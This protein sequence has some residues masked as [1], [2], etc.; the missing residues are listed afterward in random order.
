MLTRF[1]KQYRKTV[2]ATFKI[3]GMYFIR[4]YGMSFSSIKIL[5]YIFQ[6]FRP[7]LQY[8][9]LATSLLWKFSRR[10]GNSTVKRCDYLRYCKFYTHT[11]YWEI[12]FFPA[13]LIC[14]CSDPRKRITRV[15]SFSFLTE[16]IAFFTIR[17]GGISY[18][19]ILDKVCAWKK[20]QNSIR[21]SVLTTLGWFPVYKDY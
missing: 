4:N 20:T 11:H 3:T 10:S 9:T 12:L 2:F 17:A 14:F 18:L 7:G 5:S 6:D 19:H 8:R 16:E 1:K 13:M 21:Y 15:A